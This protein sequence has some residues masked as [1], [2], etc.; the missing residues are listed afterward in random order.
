MNKPL[1]YPE[2]ARNTSNFRECS[3]SD[4]GNGQ[5]LYM[6][7]PDFPCIDFDGATTVYVNARHCFKDTAASADSFVR[8]KN[9]DPVL[10]EFKSGN[11]TSKVR[12]NLREKM[13]NSLLILEAI[14]QDRWYKMSQ[15]MTFI[16]VYSEEKNQSREKK[17]PT[18]FMAEHISRKADGMKN[19][20]FGLDRYFDLYFHNIYTLTE[21]EFTEMVDSG[22][23]MRDVQS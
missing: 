7:V 5:T 10:I 22:A 17:E 6:N 8:D 19:V 4:S 11:I 16:L 21:K 20:L 9:G 13:C 2:F 23:F 18:S 12:K 14:L 3:H 15:T 1:Q